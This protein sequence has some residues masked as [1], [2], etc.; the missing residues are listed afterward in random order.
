MSLSSS[1]LLLRVNKITFLWSTSL[2]WEPERF[3][4]YLLQQSIISPFFP[5]LCRWA[6]LCHGL[7][8]RAGSSALNA[9]QLEE[10][11]PPSEGSVRKKTT[12][13]LLDRT[14]YAFLCFHPT[15][16]CIELLFMHDRGWSQLSSA[17]ANVNIS[18]KRTETLQGCFE[19]TSWNWLKK[20]KKLLCCH[21]IR[22]ISKKTK[23]GLVL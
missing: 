11:R 16:W 12:F 13:S 5:G 19:T 3:C 17:L 18:C 4:Q 20:E 1:D 6:N 14:Q 7:L 23:Q 8:D 10:D 22:N 21:R 2:L 15:A 9:D